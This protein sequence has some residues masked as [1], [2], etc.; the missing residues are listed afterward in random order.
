MYSRLNWIGLGGVKQGKAEQGGT[1][2]QHICIKIMKLE[3][4]GVK[5]MEEE[6]EKGEV[7]K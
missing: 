4:G 5:S 1:E 6:E 7:V 2:G 3:K